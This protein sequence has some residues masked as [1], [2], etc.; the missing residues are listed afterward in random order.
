[1]RPA[2][3]DIGIEQLPPSGSEDAIAAN[4]CQCQTSKEQE[5]EEGEH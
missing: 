1:M 5:E 2:I 4:E 3:A